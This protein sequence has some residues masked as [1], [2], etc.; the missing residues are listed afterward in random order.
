MIYH[1]IKVE[2]IFYISCKITTLKYFFY[3]RVLVIS[4]LTP[5][6]SLDA[7]VSNH[8]FRDNE[9]TQ[10]AYLEGEKGHQLSS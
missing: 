4:N 9:S 8:D 10:I 5:V 6:N 1:W 3:L 2:P 7:N